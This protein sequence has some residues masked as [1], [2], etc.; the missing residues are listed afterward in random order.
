MVEPAGSDAA[1]LSSFSWTRPVMQIF[2]PS[3]TN[4]SAIALPMPWPPP[5]MSATF[6]L[7]FML[8]ASLT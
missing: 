7:R 6:P 4:R 8:F 3:A 5:V 2:A 1:I